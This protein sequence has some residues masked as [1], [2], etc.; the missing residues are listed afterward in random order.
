V[1]AICY[2]IQYNNFPILFGQWWNKPLHSSNL[3]SISEEIS[4]SKFRVMLLYIL[5]I[6]YVYFSWN[7]Y[8]R[9][10]QILIYDIIYDKQKMI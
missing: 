5:Y 2:K 10:L 8:V 3:S 4:F 6:I 9:Y 1:F 7:M